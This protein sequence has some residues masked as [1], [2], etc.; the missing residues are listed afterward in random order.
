MPRLLEL[1]SESDNWLRKGDYAEALEKIAPEVAREHLGNWRDSQYATIT[2]N[3]KTNAAGIDA[4]AQNM[5]ETSKR[6]REG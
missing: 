1:Y 2:H 6:L 5:R 3:L 4:L